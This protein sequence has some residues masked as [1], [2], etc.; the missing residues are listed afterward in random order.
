MHS[1]KTATPKAAKFFE[2]ILNEI[3]CDQLSPFVSTLKEI[4]N[5]SAPGDLL[6]TSFILLTSNF[7]IFVTVR[8][9]L[10]LGAQLDLK[11][12]LKLVLNNYAVLKTLTGNSGDI[13][14]AIYQFAS[15]A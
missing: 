6:R 3:H 15:T 13:S 8:M 7:D 12:H 4:R 10:I 5:V 11:L 2:R 1:N 9:M 14:R